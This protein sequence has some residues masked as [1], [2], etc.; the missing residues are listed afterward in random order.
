MAGF[1]AE[2]GDAGSVER[3]PPGDLPYFHRVEKRPDCPYC[4]GT[5]RPVDTTSILDAIYCISLQEQP[6]R[7]AQAMAQFHQ[8]GL[9]RSVIFFRPKRPRDRGASWGVWDS[10]RR[11][12]RHALGE[13]HERVL[14]FEDDVRLDLPWPRIVRRVERVMPSM[15][16]AWWGL[17]L[18]HFPMQSYFVTPRLA[19]V[20]SV[21]AHAYIA[22]TPLL[23]WLAETMPQ[24]PDVEVSRVV[25]RAMDGAFAALPEMYA[26]FPLVATQRAMGDRPLGYRD[27]LILYGARPAEAVA[28]LFSPLHWLIMEIARARSQ[29][30]EIRP[31]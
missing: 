28:A 14:I 4:N 13:G 10:H 31:I 5:L 23:R 22:N 21:C 15:P 25:G 20:R 29:G 19:R 16:A 27:L 11:V 30:H 3:S 8:H 17:F 9:C 24:D 12:A 7:T 18:G 26:L 1:A 6:R 2:E